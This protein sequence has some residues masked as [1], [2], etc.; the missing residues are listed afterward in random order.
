MN[1]SWISSIAY[2]RIGEESYVA[3]FL[4]NRSEAMLYGP[5]LPSWLPGLVQAGTGGKSVGHAYHKLLRGK[6]PYQKV[7]G[8]EKVREL[9]EM[10]S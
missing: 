3:V 8:Q 4:K 6:F 2:K 7:E 1:S 10:M 9:K 5:N